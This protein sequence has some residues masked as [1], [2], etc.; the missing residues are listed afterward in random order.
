MEGGGEGGRLEPRMAQSSRMGAVGRI[1]VVRLG[2]FT[3]L[4]GE[5]FGV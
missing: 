2:C 5:G 4:M 1:W 3:G